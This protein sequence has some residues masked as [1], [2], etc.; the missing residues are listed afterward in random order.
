MPFVPALVVQ[1]IR[2]GI[3]RLSGPALASFAGAI[4]SRLGVTVAG[5]AANMARQVGQ[6]VAANP[7]S[8]GLAIASLASSSVDFDV[9]KVIDTWAKDDA[10][11]PD[12]VKYI[13]DQVQN[14]EDH[15]DEITG[16]QSGDEVLGVEVEDLRKAAKVLALGDAQ[17]RLLI[18][19]FGDI[20]TVIG[21]RNALFALDDEQ[22]YLFKERYNV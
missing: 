1:A 2:L 21:V 18:D 13:L 6:Y 3:S 14:L 19:Q 16:D 15:R 11:I 8:A 10:G 5:S 9:Q 7:M 17:I 22:F 4:S 12:D 20:D